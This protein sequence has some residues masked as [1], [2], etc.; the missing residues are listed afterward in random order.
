M[1]PEKLAIRS[2]P[3]VTCMER[4]EGAA[5]V[6]VLLHCQCARQ[7]DA[8]TCT[9]EFSSEGT[10]VEKQ[11]PADIVITVHNYPQTASTHD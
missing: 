6:H 11:G 7:R 3:Y 10:I 1:E 9:G 5:G 4:G 2:L 8:G